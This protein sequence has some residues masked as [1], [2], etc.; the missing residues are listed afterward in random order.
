MEMIVVLAIVSL[1]AGIVVTNIGR[2]PAFMT[3]DTAANR[4]KGLYIDAANL[5]LASGAEAKILFDDETRRL[6]VSGKRPPAVKE[7]GEEDWDA[8]SPPDIGGDGE[9]KA[10]SPGSYAIPEDVEFEFVDN[11][12]NEVDADELEMIFYPDGS[13]DGPRL[14]MELHGHEVEIYVSALTGMVNVE[15]EKEEE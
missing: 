14:K 10:F 2:V 9:E 1:V 3:I 4:I 12:D 15:Y 7:E 11:D 6:T 13:A 8:P 5:A